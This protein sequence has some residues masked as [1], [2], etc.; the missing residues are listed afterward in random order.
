MESEPMWRG[1]IRMTAQ[2]RRN[3]R[4][5]II[6]GGKIADEIREISKKHHSELEVPMAE[7]KMDTIF[8]KESALIGT[9]TAP[10]KNPPKQQLT[11]L[12]KILNFLK[13]IFL[14]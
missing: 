8:Q 2:Q 5:K 13:H 9:K 10:F 1:N 14:P 3:M 11:F 7:T 6:R 12:Q 4:A